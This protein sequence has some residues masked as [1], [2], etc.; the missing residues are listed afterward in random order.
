MAL[1]IIK[2]SVGTESLADLA[3]WQ[4]GRLAVLRAARKV[5]ELMH[6]TRQM[7]RRAAEVL[8]GGSIY[9]VVKGII[10]ARQK[11]LELRPLEIDGVAHCG[12]VYDAELVPVRSQPRRAFQGWRYLA[13]QDAPADLPAGSGHES[14]P[15]HIR[16][17]L[18]AIGLL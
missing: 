17:E 12:L 6:V 9:W 3:E 1:H 4:Q 11:M 15:E 5:P 18:R 2:L 16:Q 8:D 7:P 14:L 10:V 13:P